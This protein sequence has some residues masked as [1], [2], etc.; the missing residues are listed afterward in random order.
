M[1]REFGANPHDRLAE[2]FYQPEDRGSPEHRTVLF[3]GDVWQARWFVVSRSPDL[4]GRLLVN[5]KVTPDGLSGT[6]QS[7]QWSIPTVRL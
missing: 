6:R 2:V 5:P 4:A 7:L 1:C 3:G